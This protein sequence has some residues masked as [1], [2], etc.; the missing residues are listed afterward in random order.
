MQYIA[1]RGRE[2]ARGKIP[3]QHIVDEE[4]VDATRVD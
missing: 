2:V 4:T 1:T 3:D